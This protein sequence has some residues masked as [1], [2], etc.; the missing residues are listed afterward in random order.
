MKHNVHRVLR[1]SSHTQLTV[2]VKKLTTVAGSYTTDNR[3]PYSTN[4]FTD[5]PLSSTERRKVW[6]LSI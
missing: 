4:G 2:R 5:G 6:I 1:P 3:G